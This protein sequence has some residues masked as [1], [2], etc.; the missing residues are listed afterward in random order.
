MGT[1]LD[2]SDADDV[3]EADSDDGVDSLARPSSAPWSRPG[4]SSGPST[5][6]SAT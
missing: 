3:K 6:D 1:F 4:P 5:S 2:D